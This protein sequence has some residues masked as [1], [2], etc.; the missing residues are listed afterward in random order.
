MHLIFLTLIFI[1]ISFLGYIGLNK[2]S[3]KYLVSQAEFDALIHLKVKPKGIVLVE[4]SKCLVCRTNNKIF[5]PN[6]ANI[7]DYIGIISG[8]KMH[9]EEKLF[10]IA[11]YKQAGSYFNKLDARYIF[12]SKSQGFENRLKLSPGD[13]GIRKI[14]ENSSSQIWESVN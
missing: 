9:Y 7:R 4:N 14:Y 13:Y 6:N 8:K 10:Q 2:I 1:A 11:N 5:K 3:N 12:I